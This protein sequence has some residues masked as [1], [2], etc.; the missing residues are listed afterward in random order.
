MLR[1]S[2]C[3]DGF[4][5]ADHRCQQW[6]TEFVGRFHEDFGEGSII[7]VGAY[8]SGPVTNVTIDAFS[9]KCTRRSLAVTVML[10]GDEIILP[11]NDLEQ[12]DI[13]LPGLVDTFFLAHQ[14]AGQSP[15]FI[16]T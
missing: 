13:Y 16:S 10:T 14:M 7:K 9:A 2:D 1:I 4:F 5:R 15:I 3:Y 8:K 11:K 12:M 6:A